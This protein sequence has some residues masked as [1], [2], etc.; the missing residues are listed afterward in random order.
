MSEPRTSDDT[1]RVIAAQVGETVEARIE[2]SLELRFAAIDKAT[3]LAAEMMGKWMSA[4][5]EMLTFVKQQQAEFVRVGTCKT[6][7]EVVSSAIRRLEVAEARTAGMASQRSV[8][9]TMIVAVLGVVIGIIGLLA[10]L[11]PPR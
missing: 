10:V 1:I 5:N 7:H 2:K 11:T 9:F 3:T 6:A 8:N 4:H